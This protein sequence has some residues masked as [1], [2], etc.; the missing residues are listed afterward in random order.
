MR[1]AFAAAIVALLVVGWIPLIGLVAGAAV[2][3]MFW[4]Y[5]P[6]RNALIAIALALQVMSGLFILVAGMTNDRPDNVDV[7]IQQ[8]HR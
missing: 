3:Y 5:P 4:R 7:H 1:L 6:M 2:V 8:V